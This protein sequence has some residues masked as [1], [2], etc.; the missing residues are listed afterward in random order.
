MEVDPD[1]P[2]AHG[3]E[4][5]EVLPDARV[6]GPAAKLGKAAVEERGRP[7][8]GTNRPF[9]LAEIVVELVLGRETGWE[10]AAASTR[11]HTDLFDLALPIAS[12]WVVPLARRIWPEVIPA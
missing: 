3:V 10:A 4:C 8:P 5:A 9:A 1:P 6:E 7:E 12:V 2:E 11:S